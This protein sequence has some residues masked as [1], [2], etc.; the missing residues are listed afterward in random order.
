M[1]KPKYTMLIEFRMVITSDGYWIRRWYKVSFWDGRNVP[2]LV[3]V[4]FVK[5][6]WA[7]N[8]RFVNVTVCR[9]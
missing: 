4:K 9:L 5:I 8:L 7:E 2:Q 3:R 6:N 1:K